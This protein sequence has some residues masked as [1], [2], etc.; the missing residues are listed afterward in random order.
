MGMSRIWLL[1][2]FTLQVSP[3]YVYNAYENDDHDDNNND[4]N[5]TNNRILIW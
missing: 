1:Q 5:N 4:D 2:E 3:A